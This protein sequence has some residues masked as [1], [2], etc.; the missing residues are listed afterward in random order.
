MDP[1]HENLPQPGEVFTLTVDASETQLIA[2]IKKLQSDI[3]SDQQTKTN[4][5]LLDVG[6]L[7][8]CILGNHLYQPLLSVKRGTPI[9]IA[10]VALNESE[11]GFVSALMG[12][13]DREDARLASENTAIYL[14]R[15]KSRGSGIGFFEAGNFYPDFILWAVTGKKQIVVFVEPHGISHEGPQ[16]PK[17]QF[18]KTIKE[19]EGRLGDT[20]LRLE[21]A[22]VTPT[23]YASVKDRGLSLQDWSDNHVFFMHDKNSDDR[24]DFIDRVMHLV[25]ADRNC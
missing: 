8:A 9:S 4:R 12:W 14:L 7:K 5:K 13:L 11:T 2:D 19:I 3:D 6:Q 25:V 17:V 23:A 21:S 20:D 18:H 24:S 16:H 15:N 1:A 22:I 10:P